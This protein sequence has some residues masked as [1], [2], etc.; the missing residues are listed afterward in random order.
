MVDQRGPIGAAEHVL[1]LGSD[2]GDEVVDPRHLD[3]G[4]QGDEDEPG[5]RNLLQSRAAVKGTPDAT[6]LLLLLLFRLLLGG[7]FAKKRCR[8]RDYA[9]SV[10]TP[11]RP[12]LGFR[13]G[14]IGSLGPFLSLSDELANGL[15]RVRRHDENLYNQ[16][17]DW[18]G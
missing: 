8:L 15:V 16:D 13:V 18:N 6:D 1:V 2:G 3:D 10:L 12:I 9:F 17:E 14:G 11:P 4:E 5:G 7:G